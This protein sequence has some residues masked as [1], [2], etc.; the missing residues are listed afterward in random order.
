M[1]ATTDDR[2]ADMLAELAEMDLSAARHVH[3]QLLA[4]TEAREVADL[5]RSY[6]RASRCLRQTLALK[7]KLAQDAVVHRLRTTPTST[8]DFLAMGRALAQE[9]AQFDRLGELQDAVGRLIHAE[10]SDATLRADYVERLDVELDDWF[11]EPDFTT[12][13]LDV[14]VRRA[15][16][17]L[18]LS[19]DLASRWRDLPEAPDN[20]PDQEDDDPGHKASG[21]AP[22]V[23]DTG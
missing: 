8:P 23:A 11:V 18:G 13:H 6:Q 14:Q 22:P 4:A 1:T 20:P 17:I 21:A 9:D 16:R 12:E 2:G 15:C 5:S 3:A 10:I 7:A 19:G